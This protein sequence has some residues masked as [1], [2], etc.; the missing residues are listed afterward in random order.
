[1]DKIVIASKNQGKID[2]IKPHLSHLGF[3]VFSMVDFDV[4]DI[5]ETGHTL[6]E[7][8]F[9]KARTVKKI[10]NYM[11]LADDSGLMCDALGGKP[12]VYSARYAEKGNDH[13]NN[14]KLLEHMADK[15]NRS[16]KFLTVMVLID[17]HEKEFMFEGTLPGYIHTALEGEEGFGY[18]PLFIPVGHTATLAQLGDKIKHRISHRKKALDQVI[19]FLGSSK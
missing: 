13:A 18:D 2:E 16:A 6:K 4:P 8:A 10:T 3:E 19:D 15:S 17:E 12:G 1:M 11:V 5:D 14:L 7:N 9:I